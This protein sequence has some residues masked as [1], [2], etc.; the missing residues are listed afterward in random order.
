[1]DLITSESLPSG[2]YGLEIGFMATVYVD[3]GSSLETVKVGREMSW[4]RSI[5][6]DANLNVYALVS[7]SEPTLIPSDTPPIT[8]VIIVPKGYDIINIPDPYP[9]PV[10]DDLFQFDVITK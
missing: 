10:P 1:M 6:S 8:D 5:S 4:I 2:N 9:V 3:T 7:D